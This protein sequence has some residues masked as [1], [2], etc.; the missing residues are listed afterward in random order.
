MRA[1][2]LP[3]AGLAVLLGW[4]AAIDA[5]SVAAQPQL[6]EFKVIVHPDNPVGAI[7]AG[8]LR[9]AYL[10]KTP[11]WS[12]GKTIRPIDLPARSA[13]RERFALRILKKTPSQLRYY[14][15]RR[16]FSGKGV[17]PAQVDSVAAAVAFVVG[18]PGAVAYLPPDAD[19]GS[20]KVI[21]V[22]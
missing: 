2:L 22:R 1:R 15:N 4:L 19:T 20:A 7:D 16:V 5:T 10:K 9:D 18:T 3:I 13:V 8:F 12:N 21:A 11:S 17:P 14:W 6:P